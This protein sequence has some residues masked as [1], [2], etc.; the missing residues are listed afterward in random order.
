MKFSTQILLTILLILA[1]ITFG[2]F[3]YI[4]HTSSKNT[5]LKTQNNELSVQHKVDTIGDK[6][7]LDTIGVTTSNLKVKADVLANVD[8][9]SEQVKDEK[10]SDSAADAAYLNSMWKAYCTAVAPRQPPN[11]LCNRYTSK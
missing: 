10:I 5:K 2:E 8:T 6:I 3:I 1:F 7:T 9:I 4:K 11:K